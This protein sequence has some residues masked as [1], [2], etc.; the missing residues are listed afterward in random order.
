MEDEV[1]SEKE[2]SEKMV[3]GGTLEEGHE[4]GF[5]IGMLGLLEPVLKSRTGDAMLLG[6]LALRAEG[7]TGML[8]VVLGLGGLGS[9]PAKGVW[10]GVRRG[11]KLRGSHGPYP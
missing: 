1:E 3:T 6:E 9:I 11:I 5:E 10:P 8:K 4:F 2:A 7:A